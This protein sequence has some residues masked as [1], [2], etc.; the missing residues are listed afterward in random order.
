VES[1]VDHP[2]KN[3]NIGYTIHRTKTNKNRMGNT[4]D[5]LA[6]LGTQDTGRRQIK[7]Q[8]KIINFVKLT[9][10]TNNCGK[11]ERGKESSL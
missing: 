2:E 8:Y 3:S 7:T 5:T 11:Y 6:T 9:S 4:E 10:K 1:R